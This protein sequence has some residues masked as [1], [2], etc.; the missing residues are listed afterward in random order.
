MLE[1]KFDLGSGSFG[2]SFATIDCERGRCTMYEIKASPECAIRQLSE[3]DIGDGVLFVKAD[4]GDIISEIAWLENGALTIASGT[5]LVVFSKWKDVSQ[6]SPTETCE[7]ESL[8][9][10]VAKV[11][12]RLPDYHPGLLIH[13]LIWGKYEFIKFVFSVV[14][15]FVELTT[16]SGDSQRSLDRSLEDDASSS[17]GPSLS[18]PIREIPSVLWKFFEVGSQSETKKNLKYDELFFDSE[19]TSKSLDVGSFSQAH[20]DY[21]IQT[22]SKLTLPNLNEIELSNLFAMMDSFVFVE[23]QNR[24]VDENGRRFVFFA[25]LFLASERT[26]GSSLSMRDISWAFFSDSQD[27]LLDFSSQ[28][29]GG[30]IIWKDARSFGMGFWLK[31]P[32]T[33]RR[34]V[35]TMARNQYMGKEVKDPVDCALF[36]ICLKKKNVLL[37]LWKLA[38]SHPEQPAMIKFLANDFSEDRW[39]KA[40]LKNAFALLGKQRYEYAVAFF[41]LAEK[42]KDAV[43]VCLKHLNDIQLAIVLCR[44]YEG[45]DSVTLIETLK[46]NVIPKALLEG[47][48]Y[49]LSI[50]FTLMKEKDLALKSTMLPLSLISQFESVSPRIDSIDPPLAVITEF[51]ERSYRSMRVSTE[52]ISP[53]FRFDFMSSSAA[54]YENMGCPGLALDMLKNASDLVPLVVT[55]IPSVDTTLKAEAISNEKSDQI[56]WSVPAT[57]NNEISALDW[58]AP[59]S[60]AVS[61]SAFGFWGDA[62][63]KKAIDPMDEYEAFKASM[64]LPG[65]DEEDELEKEMRLLEEQLNGDSDVDITVPQETHQDS[66]ISSLSMS[67]KTAADK[68]LDKIRVQQWKL[69]MRMVYSLHQS[70]AEVSFNMDLLA[71]EPVF[72]NYFKNLCS[73]IDELARQVQMPRQVMDTVLTKRFREMDAFIAFAELPCLESKRPTVDY[74]SL[75]VEGSN[76]LSSMIFSAM[77]YSDNSSLDFVIEYSKRLLWS[78]ICWYEKENEEYSPVG[79]SVMSQT[80]ATAFLALTLCYIHVKNFRSL[81]WIVGLSD[82]FFEVLVGGAKKRSLKP[83]ILDLLSERE[84]I[85][86]PDSDSESDSDDE[87]FDIPSEKALLAENFLSSIALQ[88]VGLDFQIFVRHLK[89]G[90]NVDDAYGFLSEVVLKKL[91]SRL[92]EMH[93]RVRDQWIGNL[94]FKINRI[95]LYLLNKYAKGV[96]ALIKRTSN[97]KKLAAVIISGDTSKDAELDKPI[98]KMSPT[99]KPQQLNEVLPSD[100]SPDGLTSKKSIRHYDEGSYELV[101][102]TKDIIGNFAINPVDQTCFAV[103]SHESIVE[104]ELEASLRFHSREDVL[105]KRRESVDDL[106]IQAAKRSA[107]TPFNPVVKRV[108]ETETIRRNLSYDSLQ[109]AVK[110]SMMDLRRRD[111]ELDSGRRIHRQVPSVSALEAHP[112]LNYYLA[113]VGDGSTESIVKL[114]QFGQKGDLVSYSSG[115][116]ARIT[117]C[118][119]DPFG[120]RFGCSDAKG[121]LRLW[122]FDATEQSL[123]PTQVFVCNTA[124]TND[125]A[126]INSSTVLA[127]AGVS[128]SGSNVAI[129]DSLLP[130]HKAKVKSFQITEGGAYSISYSDR[131]QSIISGGKKGDIFIFDVRQMRH[132]KTIH[133]HE[134][135]VKSLFVDDE[136]G[137]LISGSAGGDI[138]VWDLSLFNGENWGS[139]DALW[140]HGKF[141]GHSERPGGMSSYG[142]MQSNRLHVSNRLVAGAGLLSVQSNA[143]TRMIEFESKSGPIV[144]WATATLVIAWKF[145]LDSIHFSLGAILVVILAKVLKR[146]LRQPRPI[147]SKNK[148]RSNSRN[149]SNDTKNANAAFDDYGMPS[150]HATTIVYM[151]VYLVMWIFDSD[152]IDGWWQAVLSVLVV[153][154]SACVGMSRVA[155]GHHT[156][157]QVAVGAVVGSLFGAGWRRRRRTAAGRVEKM[158]GAL[159]A[160]A[161]SGVVQHSIA[162]AILMLAV[163]IM[164]TA[165]GRFRERRRKMLKPNLT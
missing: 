24:S 116:P 76:H 43:N 4:M 5:K 55:E 91:S 22:R 122:K 114:Y 62:E 40:A 125:F 96:W 132:R 161:D 115:T 63:P 11:N 61:S 27:F 146:V 118:R 56:D 94:K 31:N 133:A 20:L 35:E 8:Q 48:R 30:K 145:N 72:K 99:R 28:S 121:E 109:K 105:A 101:F 58:G 126:F 88:H 68:L 157:A 78:I 34:Q 124:I 49:L 71:V 147:N 26:E 32:E 45:E 23:N 163:A 143:P 9:T 120:G 119:F 135:T 113:A 90:G 36:Y 138:K 79:L 81:W 110:D 16:D 127:T 42:L 98:E 65:S 141:P 159:A 148:D 17:S 150:S 87:I 47:D 92:Y 60:A 128:A 77:F 46:T 165:R 14:A 151:A 136:N 25:R 134:N 50:C 70:I 89:D 12:G 95:P 74:S 149:G 33:L 85:I 129:W 84:P 158:L 19:I 51:L 97:V 152:E 137:M 139:D 38:A 155:L 75:L 59:V 93:K 103:A 57:K 44:L 13:Y 73:G 2:R 39:K 156:A 67:Q 111:S 18:R 142:V 7:M 6:N 117:K 3:F 41:L 80:A 153:S 69:A 29:F 164:Q 108:V 83:L 1:T 100:V 10:V 82:R 106:A 53:K 15:K 54:V 140:R 64:K 154:V 107:E 130:S 86:Q 66:T 160:Y 131:F 144:I 21:L 52:K 162:A 102:R 123:H 37:G 104:F 112:S